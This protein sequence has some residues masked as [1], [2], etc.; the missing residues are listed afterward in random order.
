MGE[1]NFLEQIYGVMLI[2]AVAG[3]MVMILLVL[4][5]VRRRFSGEDS[6]EEE[7]LGPRDGE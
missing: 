1:M 6:E 5:D 3:F 2:T 7:E 4:A